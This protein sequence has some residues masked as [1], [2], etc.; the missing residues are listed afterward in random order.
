[1]LFEIQKMGLK[2][3]YIGIISISLSLVLSFSASAAELS[4]KGKWIGV[5]KQIVEINSGTENFE[6]QEAVRKILTP[7]FTDLGFVARTQDLPNGRKLLIFEIPNSKPKV[8]F[9]GHI[10]TVF[11]K[12][13]PF[14]KFRDDGKTLHGPGIADM[15]GG[16]V[17]MAQLLAAIEDPTM[18]GNIRVVIND[19]EEIGCLNSRSALQEIAKDLNYILIFE[20]EHEGMISVGHPGGGWLKLTVTGKAAHAGENHKLGINACVELSHKIIELAKL[21]DYKKGITVNP[22]VIEGGTKPNV[23]CESASVA[24][25]FRYRNSA[26]RNSVMN[27]IEKIAAHSFLF[28]EEVKAGTKSTVK[29]DV[30]MTP[31]TPESTKELFDKYISVSKLFGL[32]FNEHYKGGIDSYGLALPGKKLLSGL[33]PTGDGYHSDQEYL[34]VSMTADKQKVTLAFLHELFKAD[35]VLSR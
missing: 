31:M 24:I 27:K 12:S 23:V 7:L 35:P 11:P 4:F 16:V 20:P 29:V 19:D 22:G 25:D 28:N 33:G 8:M 6:G 13:N 26:D 14:Q 21:T 32:K 5:L 15:K 9:V 18:R 17:M 30:D 3:K 10:D 34:D 1:M 2:V